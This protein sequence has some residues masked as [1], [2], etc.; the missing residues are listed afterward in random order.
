MAIKINYP[1][2]IQPREIQQGLIPDGFFL[3]KFNG[4]DDRVLC[5]KVAGDIRRV[6]DFAYFSRITWPCISDYEPVDI[7]I[8]V[9]PISK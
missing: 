8:T 1:K 5:M 6:S 4:C 7:E 9:K 3:G 2:E